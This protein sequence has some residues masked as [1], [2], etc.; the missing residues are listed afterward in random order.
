MDLR[1]AT[2]ATG[3]DALP[4]NSIREKFNHRYE[5]IKSKKE[6]KSEKE[7]ALDAYNKQ[8]KHPCQRYGKCGHKPGVWRCPENKNEKEENDKK[9]EYKNKKIDGICYHCNQKGHISR[10]GEAWK[11]GHYKK[12]EKAE[13]AIDRKKIKRKKFGLQKM[14]NSPLRL[15]L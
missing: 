4:I 6:E 9:T 8:Y 12:F 7:K 14:S 10:D 11:N 5:K 1:I 3:D 15:V 2:L 13:K